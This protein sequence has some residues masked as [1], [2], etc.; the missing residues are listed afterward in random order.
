MPHEFKKSMKTARPV[1]T[2]D[3]HIGVDHPATSVP[4]LPVDAVG[5][6]RWNRLYTRP[7]SLGRH[8]RDQYLS[9]RDANEGFDCP[10][11]G[12]SAFLGGAEHFLNYIGRQY[13]LALWCATAR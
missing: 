7:D 13:G 10:Y 2:A 5:P 1:E 3:I 11:E 4:Q 9:E 6:W 12:C 8:I